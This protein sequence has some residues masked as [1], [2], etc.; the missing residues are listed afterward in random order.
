[1]VADCL[2]SSACR[3]FECLQVQENFDVS[4][5]GYVDTNWVAKN[6]MLEWGP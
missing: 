3:I 4:S 5:C 6:S 2:S 1:M